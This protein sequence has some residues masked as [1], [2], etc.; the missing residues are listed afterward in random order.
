MTS[1]GSTHSFKTLLVQVHLRTGCA[2]SPVTFENLVV[3]G[4]GKNGAVWQLN[5]TLNFLNGSK[6]MNLLVMRSL[7]NCTQQLIL[8]RM[9]YVHTL[10]EVNDEVLYLRTERTDS[11]HVPNL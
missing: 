7:K 1:V 10:K 6:I 9:K 4:A 2:Y 3:Y 5:A 11:E 8:M